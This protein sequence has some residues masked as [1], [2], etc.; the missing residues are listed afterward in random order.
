M[1]LVAVGFRFDA[2]V[3]TTVITVKKSVFWV[4][5][6]RNRERFMATPGQ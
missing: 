2:E 6:V 1:A 3:A 5:E 4:I